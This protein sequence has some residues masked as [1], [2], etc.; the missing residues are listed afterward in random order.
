MTKKDLEIA[1]NILGWA[2]VFGLLI[3]TIWF[4]IFLSGAACSLNMPLFNLT[5]HECELFSYGGLA[6][7]KILVIVFLVLP[8]LAIKLVQRKER[9]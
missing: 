1:A 7:T 6:I 5:Q 4:G 3:V 8:W 2:A 9:V